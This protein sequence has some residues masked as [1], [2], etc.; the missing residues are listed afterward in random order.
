M[1]KVK[2]K[3]VVKAGHGKL[4]S[5]QIKE[6]VCELLSVTKNKCVVLYR[7]KEYTLPVSRVVPENQQA[8]RMIN[9]AKR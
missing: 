8:V 1:A 2:V 6:V 4:A 9:S 7:D 3:L 5:V